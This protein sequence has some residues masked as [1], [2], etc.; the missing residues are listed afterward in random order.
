MVL[1]NN[2]E[3]YENAFQQATDTQIPTH[4]H[5]AKSIVMLGIACTS[6]VSRVVVARARRAN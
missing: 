6:L 4:Y 2:L 3:I 1:D 5:R